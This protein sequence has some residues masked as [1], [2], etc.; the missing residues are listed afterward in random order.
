MKTKIQFVKW[1]I[2]L[3]SV[4]SLIFYATFSFAQSDTTFSFTQTEQSNAI[5]GT[6]DKYQGYLIFDEGVN[7]SVTQWKVE[8]FNKNL[9]A[10]S[11]IALE[12]IETIKPKESYLR[13]DKAYYTRWDK[14]IR[15]TGLD[16][17]GKIVVIEDNPSHVGP[18]QPYY[19][20]YCH[21]DCIAPTYALSVVIDAHYD[22]YD[23]TQIT[24]GNMV[25]LNAAS[26]TETITDDYGNDIYIPY[27]RYMSPAEKTSL[28]NTFSTPYDT[29]SNINAPRHYG[30]INGCP[31]NQS[32]FPNNTFD[33]INFIKLE[34]VNSG[35]G[36][37]NYQG[38]TL[39]GEV[40]GICK[41]RGF[42]ESN[43]VLESDPVNHYLV[44]D[45]GQVCGDLSNYEGARNYANAHIPLASFGLELLPPC[46]GFEGGGET[47]ELEGAEIASECDGILDIFEVSGDENVF[48]LLNAL[49]SADCI[50]DIEW[51]NGDDEGSTFVWPHHVIRAMQIYR[52]DIS[53]E[54]TVTSEGPII[55]IFRDSVY[56]ANGEINFP[57]FSLKKGLYNIVFVLQDL[58]TFPVIHEFSQDIQNH[59]DES[60]LLTTTIYPVPLNDLFYTIKMEA[61]A[62]MDFDYYVYDS[63]NT[64]LF[65]HHCHLNKDQVFYLPVLSLLFPKGLIF[66]KFVFSDGSQKIVTTNKNW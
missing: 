17:S 56:K 21:F 34:G 55:T 16:E 38:G 53:K 50:D 20:P 12:L 29:P 3:L 47:G 39:T 11:N 18:H 9:D 1:K 27:Y 49:M 28:C 13:V 62:T 60:N 52:V 43:N 66:H 14:L 23:D 48:E 40:Y 7:P 24:G 51:E 59:F 54:D 19:K 45:A 25:Q 41:A 8:I 31:T 35:D 65:Q 58:S 63:N 36:I 33:G 22:G 10:D 46:E 26:S 61:Q 57:T 6:P 30:F 4:S 32:G 64:S 37:K 44:D 2:N 42:W 15:V 5:Y